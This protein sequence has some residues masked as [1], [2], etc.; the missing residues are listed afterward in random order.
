MLKRQLTGA[1]AFVVGA[2][3]V[4]P[5]VAQK[6]AGEMTLDPA[7]AA[8][9]FRVRG[10]S[11]YADRGFPTRPLWGDTH[12]HTANSPDAF[13]FGNRLGPEE[14]YRFARGETVTSS[15]GQRVQLSRPLDFL[16]VADH[17]VAMGAVMELYQGNPALLRDERLKR[18]HLMMNE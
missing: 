3:L 18:W 8:E 13:A 14:A 7:A 15:T 11:P 17:G 10:Y 12:L 5:A 4:A 16:V 9:H 2:A 6:Q 1:L